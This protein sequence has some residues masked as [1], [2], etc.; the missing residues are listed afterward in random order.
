MCVGL[1][2]RSQ[3]CKPCLQASQSQCAAWNTKAHHT[4]ICTLQYGSIVPN[5]GEA[6]PSCMQWMEEA[7]RLHGSCMRAPNAKPVSHCMFR[8]QLGLPHGTCAFNTPSRAATLN[9]PM[10]R[11]GVG[12]PCTSHVSTSPSA[13]VPSAESELLQRLRIGSSP[14]CRRTRIDGIALV[15][16][17]AVLYT[18]AVRGAAHSRTHPP[19][20][21]AQSH[22]IIIARGQLPGPRGYAVEL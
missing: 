7:C 2:L 10:K 4:C 16:R 6:E 9:G 21:I 8:M 12:A 20:T 19:R 3:K 17:V 1:E 14:R 18:D 5:L 15:L 22:E 13:F 11:A